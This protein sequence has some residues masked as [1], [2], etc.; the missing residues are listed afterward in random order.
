MNINLE[1]LGL[2]RTGGGVVFRG[3]RI[4]VKAIF[5]NL[6]C[7]LTI[8][9]IARDYSDNQDHRA[10]ITLFRNL[11]VK[12]AVLLDQPVPYERPQLQPSHHYTGGNDDC[13]MGG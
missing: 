12:L 7:G 1:E 2:E 10:E 8:R 6:A 4:P 9:Q 5:E 11:M 3:T 13:R